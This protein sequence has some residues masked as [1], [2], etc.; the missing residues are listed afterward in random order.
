MGLMTTFFSVLLIMGI[1]VPQNMNDTTSGD[2]QMW[3]GFARETITVGE[4]QAVVVRPS[5]PA[6]GQPWVLCFGLEIR[7]MGATDYEEWSP[8]VFPALLEQGFH[9]VAMHGPIEPFG[10]SH[11]VEQLHGF[12]SG[13]VDAWE[14]A[15]A[16]VIAALS[17]QGLL[18]QRY[19]LTYPE[20]VAALY[21]D[22]AVCD[23]KSWPGR[24]REAF[25]RA[26]KNDY[27]FSSDDEALHFDGNPVDQVAFFAQRRIPVYHVVAEADTVV[28]P[29][30]NGLL[31]YERAQALGA[32]SFHCA[33]E[34]EAGHNPHGLRQ[35]EHLMAFIIRHGV[36]GGA[37]IE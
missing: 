2:A 10:S 11:G 34:K 29:H 28:P 12:I 9:V 26:M 22:R 5:A 7:Y 18:A 21:L 32:A 35:I 1:N 31:M 4:H 19:A 3:N 20:R 25:W 8:G 17:R 16:P 6:P 24:H 37:S 13:V 15:P 36:R 14:L 23:F 30:E 33:V 27:G